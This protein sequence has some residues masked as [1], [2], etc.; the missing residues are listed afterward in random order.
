M[1]LKYDNWIIWVFVK[2]EWGIKIVKEEFEFGG[3]KIVLL[4]C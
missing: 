3:I 1:K 4:G 2:R